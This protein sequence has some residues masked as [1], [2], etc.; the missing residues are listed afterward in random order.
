MVSDTLELDL[1]AVVSCL[2]WGLGPELR[3][4][5]RAAHALNHLVISPAPSKV[6]FIACSHPQLQYP[7]SSPESR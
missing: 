2:T 5:A 3:S 7:G 1:Q 4:S 6:D